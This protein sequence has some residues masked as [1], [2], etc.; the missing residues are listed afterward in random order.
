MSA[1]EAARA[2]APCLVVSH[3]DCTCAEERH[4]ADAQQQR[5]RDRG[6]SGDSGALGERAAGVTHFH[7]SVAESKT[8]R[9]MS[10]E[11]DEGSSHRAR[12]L[13]TGVTSPAAGRVRLRKRERERFP[14]SRPLRPCRTNLGGLAHQ[15]RDRLFS[16]SSAATNWRNCLR[17]MAG[18]AWVCGGRRRALPSRSHEKNAHYFGVVDGFPKLGTHRTT[19]DGSLRNTLERFRRPQ[20][21]TARAQPLRCTA[22][23][24][25]ARSPPSK[26][27]PCQ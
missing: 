10:G 17:P 7:R 23:P 21:A 8:S 20:G 9:S 2:R 5:R 6:L 14:V 3:R 15:G 12:L 27:P 4:T 22:R 18:P 25:A 24:L 26:K 19:T 13:L 1:A 16:T 11:E